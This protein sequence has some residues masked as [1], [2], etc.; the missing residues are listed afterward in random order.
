LIRVEAFKISDRPLVIAIGVTGLVQFAFFTIWGFQGTYPWIPL[1]PLP[2]QETELLFLDPITTFAVWGALIIIC[3]I[4]VYAYAHNQKRKL[5]KPGAHSKIMNGG[6]DKTKT[7]SP[8]RILI[9]L[10]S[11]ITLQIFL[12]IITFIAYLINLQQ[13]ALITL[14]GILITFGVIYHFYR[15]MST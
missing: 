5:S 13:V 12:T 2:G 14:G 15:L 4:A 7:I 11:L 9:G 3:T 8:N 6:S 1:M 10:V